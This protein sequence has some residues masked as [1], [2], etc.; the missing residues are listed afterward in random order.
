VEI[1]LTGTFKTWPKAYRGNYF[2]TL[3]GQYKES[4][5]AIYIFQWI[6]PLLI[7]CYE[8]NCRNNQWSPQLKV[9]F[10]MRLGTMIRDEVDNVLLKIEQESLR[11]NETDEFDSLE[12]YDD[13]EIDDEEEE[14][15]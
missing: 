13:L 1:G 12:D 9:D 10:L 7:E 4:A 6:V 3:T 11:P 14:E 2:R 8:E 5:V 15:F